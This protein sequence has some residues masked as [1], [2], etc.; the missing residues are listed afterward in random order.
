MNK[1]KVIPSR[2]SGQID[3]IASKSYVHRALIAASLADDISIIRNVDLN[4]DIQRTI[5]GLNALGANIT[6]QSK[7]LTIKPIIIKEVNEP[8]IIDAHESGSTLRFLIPLASYLY[9]EVIFIGAESLMSRPLTVYAD[10]YGKANF[11]QLDKN[12]LLVKAFPLKAEYAIPGNI[13][14]QFITGLLFTLSLLKAD[15]KIVLTS[16]LESKPYVD[17]T[18]AIMDEFKVKVEEAR[19]S[20]LL[21]AKQN[22][23]AKDLI[24]EG[25]F[26]QAAF[27]VVL[28]IINSGLRI[29]NINMDSKQGDRKIFSLL[30]ALGAKFECGRDYIDIKPSSIAGGLIDLKD[31]PDLGPILFVLALFAKD[32]L[33]FKNIERLRI[34]ESD[35]VIAMQTQLEKFGAVINLNENELE[36][37]PLK[38]FKPV[39]FIDS[40]NDHRIAMAFSIMA[41][42]LDHP[43]IIKNAQAINKSFPAFY[44]KLEELHVEIIQDT[45]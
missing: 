20:Y 11:I 28:G 38:Q 10:L 18:L 2:V 25:D 24:A 3:I 1:V 21:K 35:R 29:N 19:D 8:I 39:E 13:S 15:S 17:M 7:I 22:Y 36:I 30:E 4:D 33:I 9:K 34:K 31:I 12:R 44:K 45:H 42:K 43:L 32:K 41:T 5:N 16:P 37:Y 26:S 14:S 27:F 40:Y 6:Y 23:Q